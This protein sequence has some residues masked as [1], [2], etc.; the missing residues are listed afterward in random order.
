MTNPLLYIRN[1]FC[2]WVTGLTHG[3]IADL[4]DN[5]NKKPQEN[6]YVS[7]SD[8][9]PD[10][11]NFSP[12]SDYDFSQFVDTD[13]LSQEYS[14]TD[15]VDDKIS[16]AVYSALESGLED[17]VKFKVFDRAIASL[18]EDIKALQNKVNKPKKPKK[19]L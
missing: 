18:K 3:E 13:F 7:K 9:D 14:T 8:F 2:F 16:E 19:N 4:I 15:E 17:H 10:D 11:Y 6:D 1:K 5:V 12:L